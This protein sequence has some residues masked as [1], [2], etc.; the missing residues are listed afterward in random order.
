MIIP[1]DSESTCVCPKDPLNPLFN[2]SGN[3]SQGGQLLYKKNTLPQ[4]KSNQNSKSFSIKFEDT[5]SPNRQVQF[6]LLI[7][8]FY[9][10]GKSEFNERIY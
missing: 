10:I 2:I 3:K 1:K 6:E 5:T 9:R 7:H 8:I 4:I